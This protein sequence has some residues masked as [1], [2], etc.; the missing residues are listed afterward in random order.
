MVF[1]SVEDAEI[2]ASQVT[3]S[4]LIHQ[5]HFDFI[6]HTEKNCAKFSYLPS[7]LL[8]KKPAASAHLA[9]ESFIHLLQLICPLNF[10]QCSCLPS[11]SASG[12]NQ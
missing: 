10:W 9:A 6:E 2:G 11:P 4:M 1:K 3:S 7:H 12:L 8:K 5:P